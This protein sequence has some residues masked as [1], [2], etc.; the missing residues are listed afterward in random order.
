M[1]RV[2][3]FSTLLIA[4]ASVLV[5]CNGSKKLGS[6]INLFPV[7]QDKQLG[8]QVA[9]EIDGN[10]KEYPLLDSA[11][12]KEIYQYL[13]K[14]RNTILN[15]GQVKH[16]DNFAWRLRIIHDD[17]TLNAFCTPGGYIYVYTGILKYLDNEAQLA[18]VLG[19]EIAHADFRHSTRQMTQMYGVE[20]LLAIVAGNRQQLSQITAGLIG[21]KFS[22]NHETE[23]DKGSVTYLC[24]TV[25]QADGGAGFFE[26]IN[27][28]GGSRTPEF[29]STHP[30]PE[31]RIEAFRNYKIE[32]ACQGV[33]D[34]T[35]EYKRMIAKL[36]K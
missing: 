29:L 36:P 5:N 13:Y 26:K 23:A 3:V 19:H 1:R 7:E 8:A 16:K 27:A 9:A 33:N 21:L 2:I 30:N 4:S 32:L 6:G 34:F 12:N 31:N 14:I 22:R 35:T 25:Y 18:G 15:S 20:A 24:P 10:P 11:S 17:S 28:S